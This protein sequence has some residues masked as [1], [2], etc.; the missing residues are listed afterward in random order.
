MARHCER[1]GKTSQVETKRKLLRGNYNPTVKFR[2]YP[3]LQQARDNE[4][5]RVK[6]CTQCLRTEAKSAK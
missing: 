1:C 4:G 3:N 5:N 6:V 2:K